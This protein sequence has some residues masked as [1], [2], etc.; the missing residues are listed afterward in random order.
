MTGTEIEETA[1][2]SLFNVVKS[3]TIPPRDMPL[4]RKVLIKYMKMTS[5]KL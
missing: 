2:L 4:Q 5:S 3:W 1:L